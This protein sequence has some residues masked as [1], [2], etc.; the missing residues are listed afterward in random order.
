[1]GSGMPA[2]QN[3]VDAGQLVDDPLR[4]APVGHELLE[5]LAR[6]GQVHRSAS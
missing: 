2:G 3:D 4:I 6:L 1:M 5:S